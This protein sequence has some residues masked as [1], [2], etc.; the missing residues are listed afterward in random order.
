MNQKSE[1]PSCPSVVKVPVLSG[2][3]LLIKKSADN[4][5]GTLDASSIPSIETS[6]V[7]TLCR[8]YIAV[9]AT[10]IS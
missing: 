8:G 6:D 1:L 7:I 4:G 2:S 10:G 3:P 9:A 5:H